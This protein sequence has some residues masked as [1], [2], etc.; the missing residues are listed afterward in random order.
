MMFSTITILQSSKHLDN[1]SFCLCSGNYWWCT[2]CYMHIFI[3]RQIIQPIIGHN[4]LRWSFTHGLQQ[5]LTPTSFG[6]GM[7]KKWWIK[8]W[9]LSASFIGNIF[10]R[11]GKGYIILL[12]KVQRWLMS[13]KLLL[14]VHACSFSLNKDTGH[15]TRLGHDL[16]R[17]QLLHP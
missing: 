2:Y 6:L 15:S 12:E 1:N 3:I 17:R 7:L 16:W 13:A 14:C 8:V 4:R 9:M 11:G 10:W 5:R